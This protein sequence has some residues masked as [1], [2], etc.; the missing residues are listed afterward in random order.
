[1]SQL[2]ARVVRQSGA[3]EDALAVWQT[4]DSVLALVDSA[5]RA[6]F[7]AQR[8]GR[9]TFAATASGM[10]V[11]ATAD[12]FLRADRPLSGVDPTA[13]LQ[14]GAVSCNADPSLAPRVVYPPHNVVLPLNLPSPVVQWDASSAALFRIT[15]EGTFAR[16]SVYAAGDRAQFP[17]DLWSLLVGA[18]AG[19]SLA[20][21]VD[22]LLA[23][24]VCVGSSSQVMKLASADLSATVYYWAVNTGQILRIDVGATVPDRMNIQPANSQGNRCTACHV[25]SRAGD[26][27]AFTYYGSNGPGGV[28]PVS[29]PST[30]AFAPSD[31]QVWN[32]AT[33]DPSGTRLVTNHERQFVLRDAT[34]GSPIAQLP[35]ANVAQPTWSPDGTTLAFA[36]NL[37]D[38][39]GAEPVWEIDFDRSDL[40]VMLY[41]AVTGQVGAPRTLVPGGNDAISY[42]S[43]SPDGRWLAYQR[44]SHSRSQWPAGVFVDGDVELARV[45]GDGTPVRLL[46][47]NP[48]HNAY[49][50]TFSPFEEGGYLW[51][52]FYSRRDYG[53]VLRDSGRQQIWVAAIDVNAADGADPSHPAFWLPGQ[54][55][56]TSNLS[57]YFAPVPCRDEGG[58]CTTDSQC[59]TGGVCRPTPGGGSV[60]TAPEDACTF[61]GAQCREDAECCPGAGTCRGAAEGGP[62]ICS[63]GGDGCKGMGER[64]AADGDCCSGQGTCEPDDQGNRVCTPG[65]PSCKEEGDPCS[66]DS[67]CCIS[68]GVC[69]GGSC[70]PLPG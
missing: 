48:D 28:V 52:A 12:V 55:P 32:Y 58:G 38:A 64:C 57:S 45:D 34:T 43:W 30:A 42:P 56:E 44:G 22:A 47:C 18:H 63:T 51:M 17:A 19:A 24:N 49:M 41:D 2:T 20:L 7:T 68:A 40:Q 37:R 21:R 59:C 46:G 36:A 54:D 70:G 65:E 23:D 69:E 39:A 33:F 16:V 15:L 25:L 29:S 50:P 11:T 31:L 8:A 3:R 53:V 1:V 14:F 5:G 35:L 4:S 10:T 66:K 61:A 62:G 26:K 9:V 67:E 6:T 60:C 27:L 13:S